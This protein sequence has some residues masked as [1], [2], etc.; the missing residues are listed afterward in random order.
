[1][2]SS[3]NKSQ[4]NAYVAGEIHTGL[5]LHDQS[6]K[7]FE[8]DGQYTLQFT[9]F[10]RTGGNIKVL[11]RVALAYPTVLSSSMVVGVE[12][13]NEPEERDCSYS[14]NLD[15]FCLE[16]NITS[17]PLCVVLTSEDKELT[18]FLRVCSDSP[19]WKKT[20]LI[21]GRHYELETVYT[22]GASE[23]I[24]CMDHDVKVLLTPCMHMTLCSECAE[25]QLR[26]SG[27]C[28]NCNAL[29]SGQLEL[30]YS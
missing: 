4:D 18:Y 17:C 20:L 24:S 16:A 12:L 11:S 14:V 29:I 6:I 21:D 19:I 27:K 26:T 28:P 22:A 10:S 8:E 13:V 7:V 3:V 1:M 30:Q 23:C 15:D 25:R 9:Y 5:S 2:G